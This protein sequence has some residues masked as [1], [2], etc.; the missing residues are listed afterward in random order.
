MCGFIHSTRLIVP[1]K[2]IGLFGSN[3]AVTAWWAPKGATPKSH[4]A[5]PE[6]STNGFRA[7]D[8]S[9]LTSKTSHDGLVLV[10]VFG[11][12]P[13]LDRAVEERLKIV[14]LAR[15]LHDHVRVRLDP[16]SAYVHP[17]PHV[18]LGIV[19]RDRVLHRARVGPRERIDHLQFF[20]EGVATRVQPCVPVETGGLDD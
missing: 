14:L 6:T 19:H 9:Y 4:V 2:V 18:G 12:F 17:I 7:I 8:A 13:D 11:N 15:V 5:R 1:V 16:P 20:A 10:L 3:S